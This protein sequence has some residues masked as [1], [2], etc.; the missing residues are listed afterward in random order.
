[1]M[2]ADPFRMYPE[3]IITVRLTRLQAPGIPHTV[4]GDVRAIVK[5]ASTAN[6]PGEVEYQTGAR[7]YHLNTS[8]LPEQLR[9]DPAN[10]IG[11][12][13]VDSERQYRISD[14]SYGSDYTPNQLRFVTVRAAPYARESL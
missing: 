6:L 1:M 11:L 5:R 9:A 3:A 8:D 2:L 4:L 7:R 14:V 10:L 13:L 12:L